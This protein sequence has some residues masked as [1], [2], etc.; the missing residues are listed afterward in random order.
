MD[1]IQ[2]ALD[3]L[4]DV[5]EKP[6]IV[7]LY[8]IP[9]SGKTTILEQLRGK[10]SS[11]KFRCFE[12]SDL[13]DVHIEGDSEAFQKLTPDEKVEARKNFITAIQTE[14]KRDGLVGIVTGDS[15]FRDE[16]R[17]RAWTDAYGGVYTYI[18]YL[19][20]PP[21]VVM[22]RCSE[23]GKYPPSMASV[24][25]LAIWQGLEKAR[26]RIFCRDNNV[27]L[28][29]IPW[30]FAAAEEV[31]AFVANIHAFSVEENRLLVPK[32]LDEWILAQKEKAPL[33]TVLLFSADGTLTSSDTRFEFW[34]SAVDTELTPSNAEDHLKVRYNSSLGSSYDTFSQAALL[35]EEVRNTN[36]EHFRTI[37]DQVA[38]EVTVRPE[39]VELLNR[40]AKEEHVTVVVLTCALAQIWE[41]VIERYG[42]SNDIK[43]IGAG[44]SLDGIIVARATK[45][46]C[47][48]HLEEVHGLYVWAFGDSSMDLGML[49][50]AHRAIIVAGDSDRSKCKTDQSKYMDALLRTD[51]QVYPDYKPQQALL[52][53]GTKPRLDVEALPLV[54][55]GSRKFIDSV[56]SHRCLQVVHATNKPAAKLLMTAVRDTNTTSRSVTDLYGDIGTYL[57]RDYL[58]DII[59]IELYSFQH[60]QNGSAEGF[61]FRDEGRVAVAGLMP[62]GGSLALGV[63]KALPK[64][65]FCLAHAPKD[66]SPYHLRR[67]D[68]IV[69]VDWC[70][71]TGKRMADFV[72]Y[73]RSIDRDMRI[74]VLAGVTSTKAIEGSGAILSNLALKGSISVVTLHQSKNK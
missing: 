11:D 65:S 16:V 12:G 26:L 40:A 42:L 21:A 71:N 29:I 53:K 43:V 17:E 1:P 39:F 72:Q 41:K 61:H 58:S 68:T 54:D 69:L 47:V 63:S 74:I 57:A 15:L 50:G 3:G 31:L 45:S 67:K 34:Q 5:A 2:V 37:C 28:K 25:R 73:I 18:L 13:I 22:Q 51:M 46:W 70:I 9:G 32:E 14:C 8:G 66:L 33:K 7:G 30:Y 59:G 56:V 36:N 23:Q 48:Y 52:P 24:D 20:V 38:A 60:A 19:D 4:P 62:E 27:L 64:A 55:V 49:K 44:T 10:L 35:Y 6:L